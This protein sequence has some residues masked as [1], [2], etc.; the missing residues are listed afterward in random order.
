[1]TLMKGVITGLFVLKSTGIWVKRNYF[2]DTNADFAVE[3]MESNESN[4]RKVPEIIGLRLL[5]TTTTNH[6]RSFRNDNDESRHRYS[7]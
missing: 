7:Y 2:D 1:M 5:D 4:D 6:H 3:E